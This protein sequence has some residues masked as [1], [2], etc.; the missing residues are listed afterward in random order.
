M[1]MDT[2][3]KK[4]PIAKIITRKEF[5]CPSCRVLL[6]EDVLTSPII[7]CPSCS[8]N[9][10]LPDLGMHKVEAANE[11]REERCPVSLKV[12]Y[13][14]A[15]EFKIEY[16]K[17][18]SQGGMFIRTTSPIETGTKIQLELFIPD[19]NEPILLSVEVVRSSQYAVDKEDAG[20]GVRFLD[21]DPLSKSILINYLSALSD[22]C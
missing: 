2:E 10:K 9:I 8:T 4:H 16:T 21:I 22:S 7:K 15:K 13:N 18:V 3:I 6:S 17:N 19:L 14:T 11:R 1:I 12:Q 20:V 5:H